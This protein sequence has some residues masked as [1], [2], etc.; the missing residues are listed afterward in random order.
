M[1]QA[2]LR[3]E[4]FDRTIQP[5][6][7]ARSTAYDGRR[8]NRRELEAHEKEQAARLQLF[9]DTQIYPFEVCTF[10]ISAARLYVLLTTGS[11]PSSGRKVR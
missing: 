1:R 6:K 9:A 11:I 8:E 3:L 10:P 4:E 7:W 5:E 2:I